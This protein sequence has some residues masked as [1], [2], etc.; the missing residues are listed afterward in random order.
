MPSQIKNKKVVYC[1]RPCYHSGR[2]Q[3]MLSREYKSGHITNEQLLSDL[4]AL[5]CKLGR[6]PNGIDIHK[7][8]S[9]RQVKYY[10]IFGTLENALKL[11]GVLGNP[12]FEGLPTSKADTL[13]SSIAPTRAQLIAEIQR[14]AGE[15]G[16]TPTDPEMR[17]FG[18]YGISRFWDMFGKWVFACEQAGLVPHSTGEGGPHRVPRYDYKRPDGKTV[19]LQGSYEVRFVKVLDRLKL[20]WQSHGEY[21]PLFW[22]D[23]AGKTHRYMPDFFVV[24]WNLYIETKGWYRDNDK[25]KMQC[26]ARDNP[27]VTVIVIGRDALAQFERTER[28]PLLLASAVEIVPG[29]GVAELAAAEPARHAVGVAGDAVLVAATARPGSGPCGRPSP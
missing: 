19:K 18:R 5:A 27:R 14:L 23:A 29:F 26:V 16:H 15:L 6:Y 1:S 8:W 22:Y 17:R 28:L 4:Y 25:A 21:P 9:N 7:T 11:A 20:A 12:V 24:P 3:R 2:T 10:R 13:R